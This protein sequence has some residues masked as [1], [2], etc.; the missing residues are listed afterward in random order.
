MPEGHFVLVVTCVIKPSV[1]VCL[2]VFAMCVCV[3]GAIAFVFINVCVASKLEDDNFL[4][5]ENS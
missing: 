3:F 5:S 4:S 1:C 2:F